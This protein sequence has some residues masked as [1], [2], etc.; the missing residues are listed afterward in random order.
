ML[1]ILPFNCAYV[2][3]EVS[4]HWA[5]NITF[6]YVCIFLHVHQYFLVL[7]VCKC[8]SL[9]SC[10]HDLHAK[11]KQYS[12]KHDISVRSFIKKHAYVSD[13]PCLTFKF[14]KCIFYVDHGLYSVLPDL[15][16]C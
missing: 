6:T 16:V 8:V 15:F 7:I 3:Y 13:V 10:K 9:V 11:R 1:D 4:L 12:M 14:I 2:M 5:W